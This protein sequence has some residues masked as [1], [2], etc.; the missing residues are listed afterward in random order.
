[1]SHKPKPVP[2]NLTA[3]RNVFCSVVT[4]PTF[5]LLR[6]EFILLA[7]I[8]VPYRF[9]TEAVF[10]ELKPVPAKL[11]AEA[12]VC[13]SVVT[14]ATFH[15][16]RST[17]I[18]LAPWNVFSI[19]VTSATFHLLRSKFILLAPWNV[20]SIVVTSATFHLL[21]SEFISAALGLPLVADVP[22][23]FRSLEKASLKSFTLLT[24][25]ALMSPHLVVAS[26][27]LG[28]SLTHS[29]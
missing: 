21:R 26:D 9:V 3:L 25:Q 1:M 2:A 5:H 4:W 8:K 6:S 14:L 15:V 17:F 18:L 11:D 22:P 19:V 27:V 10:H 24:S 28:R 23:T 20:F 29:G 12:N 7:D 13:A 16:L